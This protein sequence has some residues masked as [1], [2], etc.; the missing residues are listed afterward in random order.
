MVQRHAFFW[1]ELS[2]LVSTFF[3]G[4]G[5]GLML[6]V[7]AV[8]VTQNLRIS[9]LRFSFILT[10]GAILGLLAG[11]I[12][13]KWSDGRSLRRLAPR[14]AWCRRR[15]LWDTSSRMTFCF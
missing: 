4:L 14:S 3:N 7:Q 13:G 2:Y 11:V 12:L 6:T 8:F 9:P 10:G 5:T 15:P 1:S